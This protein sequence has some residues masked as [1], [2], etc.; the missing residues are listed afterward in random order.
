[1]NKFL[2]SLGIIA[3]IATTPA[4]AATKHLTAKHAAHAA[5][6]MVKGKKVACPVHGKHM[7]HKAHVAY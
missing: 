6:C 4:F 3:M 1:M 7:K 5:M 2:I